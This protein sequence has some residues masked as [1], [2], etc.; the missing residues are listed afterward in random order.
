[1]RNVLQTVGIY[2]LA[3]AGGA[4]LATVYILRTGGF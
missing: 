3:I 2:A 4:L 1:M